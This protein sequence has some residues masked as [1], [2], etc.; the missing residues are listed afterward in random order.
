MSYVY[1]PTY[2][3]N[4]RPVAYADEKFAPVPGWGVH[5]LMAGAPWQGIGALSDVPVTTLALGIGAAGLLL[6]VVMRSAE[7]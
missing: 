4:P 6:Y 3:Q 7:A 1:E 5:P 2:Y